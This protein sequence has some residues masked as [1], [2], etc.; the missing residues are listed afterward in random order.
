[1][2]NVE[3]LLVRDNISVVVSIYI[4]L[5]ETLFLLLCR[6]VAELHIECTRH[7]R[8]GNITDG[9]WDMCIAGPYQ[10]TSD[11]SCLVYSFGFVFQPTGGGR[12]KRISIARPLLIGSWVAAMH[13]DLHAWQA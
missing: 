2:S 3:F 7:V 5:A 13:V 8:V 11:G 6:F 10:P 9:G 1:M 12:E 4:L